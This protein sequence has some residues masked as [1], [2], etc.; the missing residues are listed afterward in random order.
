MCIN[1]LKMLLLNFLILS[2]VSADFF[3]S[4]PY[5]VI[6]SEKNYQYYKKKNYSITKKILNTI[7]LN[8]NARYFYWK[9]VTY[10]LIVNLKRGHSSYMGSFSLQKE[11]PYNAGGIL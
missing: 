9:K 4:L 2:Q 8:Q 5:C 6:K 7:L 3:D 10:Y 11:W 1:S